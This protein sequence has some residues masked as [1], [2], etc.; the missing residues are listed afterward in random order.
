[1][2]I[3]G[4]LFSGVGWLTTLGRGAS[5]IPV[6]RPGIEAGAVLA[7]LAA[8]AVLF[9]GYG[10][11]AFHAAI[12]PGRAEAALLV[13]FK[14]VVHVAL[15]TLLLLVLRARFAPIILGGPTGR[16]FWL[17]LLVL[18]GVIL[19]VVAVISPSLKDIAA[20]RLSPGVL[21]VAAG[22]AFVWVSVEAGFCDE[23]LFRGVLQTRLAAVMGTELGAALIGALIHALAHAPGLWMRAGP[24]EPGHAQ[25]LIQVVAY[26]VAV[27]SPVGVFLGVIWARTK[28]LLL[29]VL[30]HGPID[31]L[32]FIPTFAHLW[33]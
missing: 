4:V 11:N 7:Y 13:A 6:D 1:M 10:L 18:G 25:S 17:T 32:P 9:T 15:Q 3:F 16:G 19:M 33:L 22:G 24:S 14:F 8:Y 12:A 2:L 27:L 28:N 26:A 21:T 5:P 30:L 31:T 20:L 23:F 29:V